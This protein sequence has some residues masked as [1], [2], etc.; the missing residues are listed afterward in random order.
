MLPTSGGTLPGVGGRRFSAQNRMRRIDRLDRLLNTKYIIHTML[1]GGK[2]NTQR[3]TE[4]AAAVAAFIA[5][6]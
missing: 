2:L 6:V 4:L 1:G 3:L 5:G